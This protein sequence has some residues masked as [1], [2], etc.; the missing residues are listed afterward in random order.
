M[1]MLTY[2]GVTL[3]DGSRFSEAAES[4]LRRWLSEGVVVSAVIV[5]EPTVMLSLCAM[6]EVILGHDDDLK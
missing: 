1:S 3:W 5:V 4:M 6:D 2:C